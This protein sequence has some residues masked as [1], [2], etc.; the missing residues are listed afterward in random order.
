MDNQQQYHHKHEQEIDLVDLA[1]VLWRR[2]SIVVITIILSVAAGVYLMG[3]KQ[4]LKVSTAVVIGELSTIRD[5]SEQVDKIMTLDESKQL[6]EAVLIPAEITTIAK[7]DNQLYQTLFD[8]ITIDIGENIVENIGE[9]KPSENGI[10]VVSGEISD[11]Y[12]EEMQGVLDTSTSSLLLLQNRVY[13]QQQAWINNKIEARKMDLKVKEDLR[14]VE[15][16]KLALMTTKF[17]NAVALDKNEN[18]ELV[19]QAE[20]KQRRIVDAAENELLSRQGDKE[21][22]QIYL[23]RLDTLEPL[24]KQ[25][26]QGLEKELI[27]ID[28]SRTNLYEKLFTGGSPTGFVTDAILAIDRRD[29]RARSQIDNFTKQLLVE[30]PVQRKEIQWRLSTI[31]R[32]IYMAEENLAIARQAEV[33]YHVDREYRTGNLEN[34]SGSIT[35][36]IGGFEAAN[37]AE[38]LRLKASIATL[39]LSLGQSTPSI[40]LSPATITPKPGR[41]L[42]VITAGSLFL[43]GMLGCFLVFFLELISRAKLRIAETS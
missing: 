42:Y 4:S 29:E 18:E 10:I 25:R 21:R 2:K 31:E 24:L 28:T 20:L 11:K 33:V 1:A 23:T 15:A 7:G 35:T 9:Y 41:S 43:G 5:G 40:V 30:F 36:R 27:E 17:D 38:I 16:D 3:N 12:S 14:N 13:E 32:S 6:L 19:K 37:E 39:E 26:I 22:E 8:N 34:N